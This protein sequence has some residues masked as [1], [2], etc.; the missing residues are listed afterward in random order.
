MALALRIHED[1]TDSVTGQDIYLAT[2][3]RLADYW[4]TM[5]PVVNH[6]QIALSET[7]KRASDSS[8]HPEAYRHVIGLRPGWEEALEAPPPGSDQP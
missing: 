6:A 8:E 2:D 1:R 3:P 5:D 7:Q 4:T